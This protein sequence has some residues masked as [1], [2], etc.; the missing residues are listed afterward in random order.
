MKETED[1]GSSVILLLWFVQ[2]QVG[3]DMVMDQDTQWLYQLL[4]DVQLEK[5]YLRVRDGL[6]ITRQEHFAYVKESDLEQIGISKP[7]E[8]DRQGIP[9][10]IIHFSFRERRSF[11]SL[12]RNESRLFLS[13]SK[14]IVGG[15][16]TA[17][18]EIPLMDP[19]GPNPG[20]TSKS[21]SRD[22]NSTANIP[23]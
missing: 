20:F 22:R 2:R 4:A 21:E 9:P 3:R 5:F 6:N 19:K 13:S 14:A 16:E 11:K 18:S 1:R 17:Q 8:P 15:S 23:L 12:Q 7:G 10:L